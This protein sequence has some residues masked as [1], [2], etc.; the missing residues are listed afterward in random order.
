MS[1]F[2]MALLAGA[3]AVMM[4]ATVAVPSVRAQTAVSPYNLTAFP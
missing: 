4:G 1:P 2:Q 3:T